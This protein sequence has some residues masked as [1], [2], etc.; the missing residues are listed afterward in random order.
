MRTIQTAEYEELQVLSDVMYDD[1]EDKKIDN[2]VL[3]HFVH[4]LSHQSA[5][6]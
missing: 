5:R 4:D 3:R 2:K 6:I 1:L